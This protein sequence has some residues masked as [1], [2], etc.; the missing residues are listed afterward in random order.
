MFH[1]KTSDVVKSSM[2][3]SYEDPAGHIRV[4]C[5]LHLFQSGLDVKSVDTV[6][7]YGPANSVEEY[8]QETGRAGESIGENCHAI[9]MEYEQTFTW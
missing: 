4:F 3:K 8:I 7:Q 1:L 6:V 9:L 2:C 5:A